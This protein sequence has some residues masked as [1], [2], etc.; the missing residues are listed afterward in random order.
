MVIQ[1]KESEGKSQKELAKNTLKRKAEVLAA[2]DDNLP[3]DRNRVSPF[4]FKDD[5]DSLTLR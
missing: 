3:N 1:Q 4:Q 2:Y 5:I